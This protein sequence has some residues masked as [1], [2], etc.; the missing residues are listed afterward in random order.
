M[1]SPVAQLY[2]GR[3]GARRVPGEKFT[4]NLLAAYFFL[5]V[6]FGGGTCQACQQ[7]LRLEIGVG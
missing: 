7:D 3:I 4:G 1:V 6:H 2:H 5:R